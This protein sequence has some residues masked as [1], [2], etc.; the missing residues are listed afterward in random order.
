MS[1]RETEN[2]PASGRRRGKVLTANEREYTRMKKRSKGR[3]QYFFVY[4]TV[5]LDKKMLGSI[6]AHVSLENG[7]K[8]MKVDENKTEA[9]LFAQ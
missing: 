2:I 5:L 7:L 8:Q 1:V 4:I 6:D 9:F 3:A